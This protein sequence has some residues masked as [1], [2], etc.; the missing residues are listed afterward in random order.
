[1]VLLRREEEEEVV[2]EA[3]HFVRLSIKDLRM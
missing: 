2:V 1:L 3:G